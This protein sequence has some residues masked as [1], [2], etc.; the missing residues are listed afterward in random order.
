MASSSDMA[1]S[2][3]VGRRR[4]VPSPDAR[5]PPLALA[6]GVLGLVGALPTTFLAVVAVAL[7][8]LSAAAGPDPWT[9]LLLAAPLLQV[10]GATWLLAR[11][12]WL[13][14]VLAVVPVALL[15]AAVIWAA[16]TTEEAG[17]LGWPL[18]LLVVPVLAAVLAATPRVRHWVATRPRRAR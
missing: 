13:L 7:G 5:M 16:S 8:G 15:T 6:A 12:S 11:R 10:L 9:Y 4:D 17:G 14:L 18:L 2:S 1:S 3:G